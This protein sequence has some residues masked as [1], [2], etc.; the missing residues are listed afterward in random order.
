M[1]LK[2]QWLYY[3][4]QSQQINN[5][6]TNKQTKTKKTKKTKKGKKKRK[7]KTQTQQPPQ[8]AP[9]TITTQKN[10]CFELPQDFLLLL[11]EMGD[12]ETWYDHHGSQNNRNSVKNTVR[13][14]RQLVWMLTSYPRSTAIWKDRSCMGITVRTPWR[15]STVCGTA[16]K[17][18]ANCCVSVSSLLHMIIGRPYKGIHGQNKKA[19]LA[20]PANQY[21]TVRPKRL[22]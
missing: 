11:P 10:N 12:R 3:T 2:W 17:L 16:R 4:K 19:T 18:Y 9:W 21:S 22:H 13:R 15:Q 7:K 6:Q 8:F 1:A 20:D 14:S 5:K